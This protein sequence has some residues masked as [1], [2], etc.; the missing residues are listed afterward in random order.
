MELWKNFYTIIFRLL[1]LKSSKIAML[2]DCE[3][4]Y[5]IT[6]GFTLQEMNQALKTNSYI[7]GTTRTIADI[8]LF[9][10][11]HS[12]MVWLIKKP[13][14]CQIIFVYI[15]QILFTQFF[16]KY[17]N[18]VLQNGLTNQEK[19]EFVNVSRWFDN[20]QQDAKLRNNLSLINFNVAAL[21]L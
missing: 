8:A 12:V 3:Y 19:A 6:D 4:Q 7:T 16:W 5:Q 20:L 13:K 2:Y 17:H 14:I 18:F 10:G 1:L 21:Y 11:L 15:V 9:Y